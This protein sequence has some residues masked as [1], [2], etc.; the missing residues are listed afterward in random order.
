[1]PEN[2]KEIELSSNLNGMILDGILTVPKEGANFAC[3][4][5]VHGSGPNDMDET[6]GNNKV[7]RDIAWQLG[8]LGVATYRYNKS[9]YQHPEL[10]IGN[11]DMTLEEETVNDAVEISNIISSNDLIDSNRVYVLGHSLGGN[12]IP[13]IA[14]NTDFVAGYV[15]MAGNTRPLED[16]MVEQTEYLINI[17]NIVTIDE[18]N[19]LDNLNVEVEKIKN[20]NNYNKEDVI[21]GVNVEYWRYLSEYDPVDTAANISAPVLVL[22]GLGDYQVTIKDYN[23]WY[24]A[25]SDYDNWSFKT[26][27]DLNHLM[28]IGSTPSVPA[29][30]NIASEVNEKVITDI[31]S[32]INNK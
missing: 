26:Y 20:I 15:I 21:L 8:E 18:Q 3:V 25:Y 22:Q 13:L 24:N 31:F 2:I 28:M 30:Y 14:Q 29:E 7:F 9:T 27:Q 16:L 19:Y 5:L 23:G 10:F 11:L 12:A 6:I 32:W 17:D 4:V 1:M